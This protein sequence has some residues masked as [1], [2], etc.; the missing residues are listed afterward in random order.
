MATITL[1]EIEKKF[2][3]DLILN[4]LDLD[5]KDEEF[6]VLVGPSGCGKST[7]L[8]LIAGLE[9]VDGGL[10]KIDDQKIN[11]CPP[12]QRNIAMVFQNYAL[13]P[14]LNVFDNISL[15]LKLKKVPKEEIKTRVEQVARILDLSHL[16]HRKPKQLS[17]GQRQ[18]VAMGRAIIRNPRVFLFDE[19]LSNLDAALRAQMRFELKKLHQKL[20]I[21]TVYVTHDQVEAMTLADRIVVLKD[22]FIQQVGSPIEV[23]SKPANKFV[24]SFIGS[25]TMNFLS[26]ED[27]SQLKIKAPHCEV[28]VRPEDLQTKPLEDQGLKL[29]ALVEN[30]EVLGSTMQLVS[31][32]GEKKLITSLHA[33]DQSIKIGCKISLYCL[34][35]HLHFFSKESGQ[36]LTNEFVIEGYEGFENTC[37]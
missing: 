2:K 1:R 28:G 24:A 3:H 25:P 26:P 29:E 6:L 17:G 4:K 11:H 10:I 20:K 5:I 35:K 12:Q 34:Y 14:H 23:Y 37:H 32:I 7:L 36:R 27:F 16:L 33:Y 8:R 9:S 18:R 21:T 15:S 22:G 30:I 31:K 19:P 13:Y